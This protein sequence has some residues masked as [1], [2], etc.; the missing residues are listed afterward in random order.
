MCICLCLRVLV[1]PGEVKIILFLSALLFPF[2]FVF[3]FLVWV[4]SSVRSGFFFLSVLIIAFCA[5]LTGWMVNCLNY[6]GCNI[7]LFVC[8]C[9]DIYHD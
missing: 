7:D 2:L 3:F 4:T 1:D 5:L 8:V 9:L 6:S